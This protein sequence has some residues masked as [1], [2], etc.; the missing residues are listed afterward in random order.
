MKFPVLARTA[1]I[2]IVVAAILLPLGLVTGK[3]TERQ[4]RAADVQAAFARETSGPQVLSGPLLALECEETVV[5]ERVV[6][7]GGK[8][9]TITEKKVRACPTAYF[10]PRMLEISGRAPVESRLRGIYPIHL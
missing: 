8:E 9:D 1:A 3:I 2:A 7:R 4:R 10:P 6:K 5:V